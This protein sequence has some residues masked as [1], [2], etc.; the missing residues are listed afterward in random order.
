MM[1]ADTSIEKAERDYFPVFKINKPSDGGQSLGF[2][3]K[4][5]G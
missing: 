3:N 5:A 1:R 4:I 2:K